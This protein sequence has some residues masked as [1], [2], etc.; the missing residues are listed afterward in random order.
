MV[1]AT[2]QPNVEGKTFIASNRDP[3]TWEEFYRYFE[4]IIGEKRTVKQASLSKNSRENKLSNNWL[5]NLKLSTRQAI[6]PLLPRGLKDLLKHELAKRHNT[7]KPIPVTEDQVAYFSSKVQFDVSKSLRLLS[8]DPNFSYHKA[9]DC[10]AKWYHR[11][12]CEQ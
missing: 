9:F 4:E 8:F 2:Y 3:L 6:T 11:F 10:I 5:S 1:G 12:Y 7:D